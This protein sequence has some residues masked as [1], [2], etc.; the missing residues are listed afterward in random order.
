MEQN[1]EEKEIRRSLKCTLH[2]I[3]VFLGFYSDCIR[4]LD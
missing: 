2:L 1:G 4:V 3:Y